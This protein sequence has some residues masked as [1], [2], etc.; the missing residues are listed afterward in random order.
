[1]GGG[2]EG[3]GMKQHVS[4]GEGAHFGRLVFSHRDQQD[5]GDPGN[6]TASWRESG[7]RAGLV[8]I[9]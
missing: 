5:A 8:N 2:H 4:A 6:D 3:H 7:K 1:M 9:G